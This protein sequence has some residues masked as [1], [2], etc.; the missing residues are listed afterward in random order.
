MNDEAPI[1]VILYGTD[2]MFRSRIQAEARAAGRRMTSAAKPLQLREKLR[3]SPVTLILVDMDMP[4]AAEAIQV[5]RDAEP[6][7]PIIAYYSHV[8]EDLRE[9]AGNAGA[10]Q[11]MP[12]SQFVTRLP[13]LLAESA[14]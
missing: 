10:T 11:V 9:S 13:I 3:Q 5:G 6:G 7:A 2:L 4:D 12:R 14:D 1:S 8:R